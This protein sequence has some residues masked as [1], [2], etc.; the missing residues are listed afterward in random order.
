MKVLT[1]VLI[2]G[3]IFFI[4]L[5]CESS[6][7]QEISKKVD[8]VTYNN[9]VKVV[10]KNNCMSCHSNNGGQDPYLETFEQVKNATEIGDLICRIDDQSCGAVMPPSGKMAQSNIDLIKKWAQTG[11]QN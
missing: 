6:T 10:V 7:Y 2:F 3:I 8:N 1:G 9:D 11:Y 4:G 5:S